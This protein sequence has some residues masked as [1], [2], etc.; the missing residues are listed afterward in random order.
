[1]TPRFLFW[2]TSKIRGKNR[3]AYS[4]GQEDFVQKIR[5]L[6][7]YVVGSIDYVSDLEDISLIFL[8]SLKKIGHPP[9]R[10]QRLE[11]LQRPATSLS[12]GWELA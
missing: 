12:N 7:R 3:H 10:P 1:M 9:L 4:Y 11:E 8:A 5:N 2:H 6:R